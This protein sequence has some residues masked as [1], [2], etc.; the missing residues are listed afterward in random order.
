MK[1]W[2]NGEK[3]ERGKKD[4]NSGQLLVLSNIYFLPYTCD[5]VCLAAFLEDTADTET[6]RT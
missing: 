6:T 3:K 5:A 2:H 4:R 1:K